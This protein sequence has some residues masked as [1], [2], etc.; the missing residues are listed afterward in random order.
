MRY[1]G[2]FNPEW[3]Y[4]AP[5]PGFV[6]A[7]RIIVV[8]A[9]IGATA[10][11]AVV[12]SLVDRPAAEESIAVRTMVQ[13]VASASTTVSMPAAVQPRA[14][15]QRQSP[16]KPLTDAPSAAPSAIPHANIRT[17]T[18]AASESSTSSTIQ[19]PAN[20]AALAQTAAKADTTPAQVA[21]QAAILP[22]GTLAQK[23]VV[24]RQI[25]SP[26]VLYMPDNRNKSTDFRFS[27]FG[28][29]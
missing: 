11:A 25:A 28:A 15:D 29:V 3:G 22:D 21:A 4:I 6:R 12:F 26:Y 2:N 18:P 23:K 10:G 7:A 13:P 27:G 14:E 16:P 24:K 19:Q 1:A 17:P 8:A 5:A 9:T 20:V